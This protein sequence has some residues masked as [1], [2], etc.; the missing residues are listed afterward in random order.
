MTLQIAVG[1][2]NEYEKS[3]LLKST[4]THYLVL[5]F[6]K[7]VSKYLLRNSSNLSGKNRLQKVFMQKNPD[8]VSIF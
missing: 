4:C 7:E 8:S 5:V 3:K 6:S 2:K 1:R